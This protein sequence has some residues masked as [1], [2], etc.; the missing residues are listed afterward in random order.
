MG[1][2]R[3]QGQ[4][5]IEL[6]KPDEIYCCDATSIIDL[7]RAG[8]LPQF[9]KL[10]QMGVIR[11]PAGVLRELRRGTDGI[12]PKIDGWDKKY[13]IIVELDSDPTASALFAHISNRYGPPFRVHHQQYVGF[14]KTPRGNK[15]AD[16]Q[17]VALAESREWTVVSNDRIVQAACMIEGVRC[18]TW[19]EVGRLIYQTAQLPLFSTISEP[20]P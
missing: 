10:M 7:N 15:S 6:Q 16:P 3:H 17:V 20:L 13:S 11:I 14:F 19:E 2:R 8:M 9:R 1:R 4:H 18:C 12:A 5:P